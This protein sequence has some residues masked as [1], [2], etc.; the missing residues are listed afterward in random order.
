[1]TFVCL[2]VCFFV[3]VD[4]DDDDVIVAVLVFVA[5]DIAAIA[6]AVVVVFVAFVEFML[7]V[8]SRLRHK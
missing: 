1:M 4:D 5:V 3:V 2:F 6:D 8:I 7:E